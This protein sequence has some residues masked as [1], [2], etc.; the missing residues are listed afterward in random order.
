LCSK[1]IYIYIY[2]YIY[3]CLIEMVAWK[4]VEFG[5]DFGI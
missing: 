5:K 2:I 1:Y 4:V 3:F